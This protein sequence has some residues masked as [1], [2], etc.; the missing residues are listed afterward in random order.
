MTKISDDLL[1]SLAPT[2]TAGTHKWEVGGVLAIAGAPQYPGASW[3]VGRSA[4]RNGAGIVYLAAPRSVIAIMASAMP[5]VACVPLPDTDAPGSARKAIERMQDVLTKVKAVVIGPG[6]GNDETTDHLLTALFGFG[7]RAHRQLS[8]FG[9]GAEVPTFDEADTL[10]GMTD[11]Q[12]V[13]DAD[14]LNWLAKQPDWWERVPPHRLVL[15]PHPGEA[16]RLSGMDIEEIVADPAATATALAEL[17]QQT[18]VIKSGYSAVSDGTQTMVS[19]LAPTSLATAGTGD[20]FAG[21]VGAFLAQGVAPID[22]A[23]LAIGIGSRAAHSLESI[24][25]VS[26]VLAS[27]LADEMAKTLHN[28]INTGR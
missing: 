22:A 9:F 24:W 10:F 26:G 7:D 17:W 12:V 27:D 1:R 15:T 13:L 16:N 4:G 28:L 25:G 6:L 20:T 3:L 2:R 18:V 19:D 5:E 21:A 8:G 11:A 14:G 23:T